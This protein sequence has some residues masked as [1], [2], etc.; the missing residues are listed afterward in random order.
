MI[1]CCNNVCVCWVFSGT[2]SFLWWEFS[3]F[4]EFWDLWEQLTEPKVL[5][6]DNPI[7]K[8]RQQ[9]TTKKK[10]AMYK[11]LQALK[12]FGIN[13]NLTWCLLW[14]KWYSNARDNVHSDV[15]KDSFIRWGNIENWHLKLFLKIR[16]FC[17]WLLFP[18]HSAES[19]WTCTHSGWI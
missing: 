1:P 11:V 5:R 13:S 19:L 8:Q 3:G 16:R 12:L 9:Q 6:W 2:R 4:W 10:F 14:T 18:V 15:S 17:A 7:S